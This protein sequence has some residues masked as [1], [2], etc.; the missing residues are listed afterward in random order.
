MSSLPRI[1]TIGAAVQDVFLHGEV[2]SAKRAHGELVE[3]FPLGAKLE[4]ESITFSTGGGAT[5]AAVTFARLGFHV[6]FAGQIAHDAA[7]Q[8][9]MDDLHLDGVDTSLV[10]YNEKTATGYSVLLVAPNGERT[11]LTYRGASDHYEIEKI[12]VDHIRSDWIF[13]SSLAGHFELLERI[14]EHARRHGIKI[15]INPGKGELKDPE[16]LKKLLPSFDVLSLNKEE[17]QQLFSGDD[18]ETLVRAAT[19]IVPIAI[20]TD[21]PNGA[22]AAD[23][24]K[25]VIAGMYEDVPVIDRTGAGDAFSSGFSAMI[26][27]GESL[28]SAVTYASANSTSV[29]GVI[30]AKKGI[31]GLHSHIHEMPLEIKQK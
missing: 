25:V 2:F 17:M 22:V 4:I 1:T 12:P 18:C 10:S 11:I 21:G 14:V 7:G 19:E 26:A 16:R 8:A 27:K 3:Q 20:V 29:V 24:E 9:V 6:G 31:L 30:G 15:A 5:N 23:R 28:E 13:I